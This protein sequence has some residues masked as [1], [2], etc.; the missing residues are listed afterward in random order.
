MSVATEIERIQ[1]AKADL[2]T[3]INSKTDSQHQITTETIDDYA[4]FVDSISTGGG[5]L[6]EKT[7]TISE[8]GTT[9]VEPDSGYDGLS[10]VTI[11]ASYSPTPPTPTPILPSEYQEVE[12]IESTGTQ[13]INTNYVHKSNTKISLDCNVKD[14][15]PNAFSALFGARK[16][17]Y[18]SNAM[19][20]FIRFHNIYQPAYCRSGA[21]T[22]GYNMIYNADINIVA[23]GQTITWTYLQDTF[24]ITT[25]GTADDGYNPMFLFNINTDISAGATVDTSWSKMKLYSCVISENGTEMRNFI[26]CYRKSDGVIGLYDIIGETFY[27]NAGTGVF[28]KGNDV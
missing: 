23:E 20:F 27:T 19:S 1:G 11:I 6:Q 28:L 12:Y 24:S 4:D 13:Y 9:V 3:A 2:K 10:R 21:E 5:N 15:A 14:D 16:R 26:P 17:N 25:T 7:I 8:D 22:A 18:S